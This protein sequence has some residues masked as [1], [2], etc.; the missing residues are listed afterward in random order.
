MTGVHEIAGAASADCDV[1][2]AQ[3]L[4]REMGGVFGLYLDRDVAEERVTVGWDRHLQ[5]FV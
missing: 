1:S 4:L 5:K 3:A 2:D